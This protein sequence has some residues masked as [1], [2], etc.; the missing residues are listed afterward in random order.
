MRRRSAPGVDLNQRDDGNRAA[1]SWLAAPA[2]RKIDSHQ[3]FREQPMIDWRRERNLIWL[4]MGFLTRVP[5][6][7]AVVYTPEN[8]NASAR[9]FPLIGLLVGC[10]GAASYAAATMLWSPAIAIVLSIAVTVFLTG[11]F[12]E[13]GWAD[14]CDGFGGGWTREQVLTIM[15]DSRLGSYGAIGLALL[16]AIKLLALMQLHDSV[17]IIPALLLGNAWSRLLS[18]S[19]LLDLPYVRDIDSSK[20]K[21]IATQMDRR[22]FAIAAA[23]VAPLIFLLP[24]LQWVC[25]ALTLSL[26]R[27]WFGRYITRRIGGY[28][29]DCLGAAQQVAEVLI[30]LVLAAF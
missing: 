7:P 28:T 30:Y 24:P 2:S 10:V 21:P 15:K 19:Y 12:H 26:W 27:W 20:I 18:I 14:S 22:A 17:R 9:Y 25:V 4:A 6:P 13:D 23:W 29:G 8:L 3:Q 16:L 11:A 1:I 5:M